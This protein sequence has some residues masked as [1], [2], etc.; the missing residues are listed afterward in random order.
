MSYSLKPYIT[1]DAVSRKF[2]RRSIVRWMLEGKDF[3]EKSSH[4]A[5][6]PKEA[7]RRYTVVPSSR[8]GTRDQPRPLAIAVCALIGSFLRG[9]GYVKTEAFLDTAL[10]MKTSRRRES[11]NS[12]KHTCMFQH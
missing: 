12:V 10:L 7:G 1:E 6:V 4:V 5:M 11:D 8:R 2:S 9:V 3:G